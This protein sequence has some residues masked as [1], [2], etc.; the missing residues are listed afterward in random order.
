MFFN[1]N[2]ATKGN[3]KGP[4]EFKASYRPRTQSVNQMFLI[5]NSLA[6]R[7]KSE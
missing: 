1:A 2:F 3:T 7:A 5:L 6:K 4:D